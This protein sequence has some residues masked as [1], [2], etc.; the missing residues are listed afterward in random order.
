MNKIKKN[1]KE[2]NKHLIE[3]I[4]NIC[5]LIMF[6]ILSFLVFY[7]NNILFQLSILSII[8]ITFIIKKI[9]I[10]DILRFN[11]YTSLSFILLI[12]IINIFLMS[13]NES[14]NITIKLFLACNL[15]YILSIILPSFKL[16]NTINILIKPLNL[17]KINTQTISLIITICITFIPILIN[18]IEK[19]RLSLVAKGIK[20][21]SLK[22]LYYMI[23]VLLPNI[24]KKVNEIEKSL[25]SKGIND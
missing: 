9:N 12:F 19:I 1:N 6:F 16:I 4:F 8:L 14:T 18:E 7:I 22:N 11:I 2:K 23:K 15:S 5:F 3:N 25:I 21:N 17:I 24:L 13:F 20:Y 10:K